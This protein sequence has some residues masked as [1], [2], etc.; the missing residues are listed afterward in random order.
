[1][2]EITTV[3]NS[4]Q[5]TKF[6]HNGIEG[7]T[8]SPEE[9]QYILPH[10][11]MLLIGKPG[12]GK[13]TMIKQLTMNP[14][15]YKGKFTETLLI[16]PS[17]MKL[18]LAVTDKNVKT[19]FDLEWIMRKIEKINKEQLQKIFGRTLE[20]TVGNKMTGPG[21][22]MLVNERFGGPVIQKRNIMDEVKTLRDQSSRFDFKGAMGKS[23]TTKD[24]VSELTR[25]KKTPEEKAASEKQ[26]TIEKA[27]NAQYRDI[28]KLDPEQRKK[29]HFNLLIILDDVVGQIKKQETN[30]M[31]AQ[32]FLNRRHLIF[33][34]TISIIVVSQKYTLI[35]ARIRSNANWM[36]MYQLN[37]VDF[38]SIYED[39]VIYGHKTWNKIIEYVFGSQST[40]Q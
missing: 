38:K 20:E 15:M 17:G 8:L 29:T 11:T 26:K 27:K 6:Q 10:F 9:K 28:E 23:A 40:Q 39:A 31:L 21:K 36:I 18:G 37:P 2:K 24:E 32:L 30:P 19:T 16:S 34:G 13:S 7:V 1:M 5:M 3:G 33:N 4:L 35:P 25:K 12:S 14:K 22:P